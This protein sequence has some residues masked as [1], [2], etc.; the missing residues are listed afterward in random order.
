MKK[1][2]TI[3]VICLISWLMASPAICE[4]GAQVA[5]SSD[6]Q[7]AVQVV[8]GLHK[9]LLESM[10]AG[11]KTT[12][13]QRY[14]RLRPYILKSFDFPLIA[15]IIL[16]RYWRK[17]DEEKRQ[18]FIGAFSNMTIATYAERFDS[19]SGESFK[20]L[21]AGLDQRGHLRIRTVLIKKNGEEISLDY[22]CR[23]AG[24]QW[25]IV[26]VSANGVNDLSLKRADYT[27]FLKDH[28]IDELIEKIEDQYEKCVPA[29]K[30]TGQSLK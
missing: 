27:S 23:K 30:K 25:R 2:P 8:E 20:T 22:T 6:N 17:M 15:R 11:D 19:F 4:Y 26:A 28:T 24:D 16:G 7:T 29:H 5:T 9:L 13:A 1:A 10:Q 18:H 21:G 12:C 3:A 14:E